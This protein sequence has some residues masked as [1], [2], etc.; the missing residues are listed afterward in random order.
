MLVNFQ[1]CVMKQSYEN[2]IF[3]LDIFFGIE[4]SSGEIAS[5]LER[6]AKILTPEYHQIQERILSQ[7]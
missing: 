5:I 4:I 6:E 7:Q 2:V 1:I 3:F